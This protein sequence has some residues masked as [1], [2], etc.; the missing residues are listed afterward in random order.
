MAART[1][2]FAQ[3]RASLRLSEAL[4]RLERSTYHDPPRPVEIEAVLGLRGGAAVLMVGA[5]EAFIRDV[6][7]EVVALIAEDGLDFSKLPRALQEHSV[8]VTLEKAMSTRV[9]PNDH[10]SDRIPQVIGAS[11]LVVSGRVNPVVFGDINSNPNS[12]SVREIF[13]STGINDVF[14]IAGPVFERKWKK[15]VSVRYTEH[16]L[17]AIVQRR[18]N[19]A[20]RADALT[21]SRQD[22]RESVRFLRVFGETLDQVLRNHIR[23]C[24]RAA[25]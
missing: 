20:H 8:F 6:C 2:A 23:R 9:S 13:R 22:L 7:P 3:Y 17:D 14:A 15:A 16:T 12:R 10:K 19:V 4:I 18:H 1:E 11:Q 5:F 21:I 25:H 24:W